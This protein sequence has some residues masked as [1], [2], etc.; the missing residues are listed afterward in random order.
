MKIKLFNIFWILI[1][2]LAFGFKAN[3]QYAK[4]HYIAPAPWN[5]YNNINEVVLAAEKGKTANVKIYKSDGTTLLR[6]KTI[7]ANNNIASNFQDNFTV[8]GGTPVTIRLEGNANDPRQYRNVTGLLYNNTDKKINITEDKKKVEINLGGFKGLIIVSNEPISFSIRN[9][10]S[11]DK[12]ANS[13]N[14]GHDNRGQMK[15]NSSLTSFGDQ[16]LG[17]QF[18]LGYYR[19]NDSQDGSSKINNN[20]TKIHGVNEL[21]DDPLASSFERGEFAVFSVMAVED[22]TTVNLPSDAIISK[23]NASGTKSAPNTVALKKGESYLFHSKIGGLLTATK[24]VTVNAGAWKDKPKNGAIDGVVTQVP[25]L[26]VLGKSYIAVKGDGTRWADR[27]IIVAT[28]DDTQIV[29]KSFK[30]NGTADKTKTITL[31]TGEYYSFHNG[32]VSDDTTPNDNN[33]ITNFSFTLVDANKPVI[34]YT[35]TAQG[36]EVDMNVLSPI[37][38]CAGSTYIQTSKFR[39]YD[40]NNLPY[41]A[42]VLTKSNAGF[43]LNNVVQ[44]ANQGKKVGTTDWYL[45]TFNNDNISN[46]ANLVIEPLTDDSGVIAYLIQQGGGFSMSGLYSSFA[47]SLK[48]PTKLGG[49]NCDPVTL[50]AEPGYLEYRWYRNGILIANSNVT[51]LVI[52]QSGNYSVQAKASCGWMAQTS[53]IPIQ[54]CGDA[55]FQVN[56]FVDFG[57]RDPELPLPL[58]EAI[59]FKITIQNIGLFDI[60]NIVVEDKL[61]GETVALSGPYKD[62]YTTLLTPT[63]ITKMEVGATWYYTAT[64][65]V[66]SQSVGYNVTTLTNNVSVKGKNTENKDVTGSGSVDFNVIK[67]RLAVTNPMLLNSGVK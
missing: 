16:A 12:N 47:P 13:L 63:E 38:G 24:S 59:K 34:V 52:T 45:Y 64:Y 20:F 15:G 21:G 40:R 22:D 5:Y 42:Y 9:V 56:K 49:E 48:Q 31:S 44:F 25:P 29:L 46:P 23:G 32:D 6:G 65:T 53:P 26:N 43:K 39:K 7:D 10:A 60:T 2:V 50:K 27:S 36:E 51:S 41:Q 1:C 37:E 19:S 4:T 67:H 58:N 28:E 66:T 11:D 33:K 18:R 3:A 57:S 14:D 55:I 30:A 54:M 8:T 35:G 62:N 17:I 61:R